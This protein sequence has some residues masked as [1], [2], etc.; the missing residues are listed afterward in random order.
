MPAMYRKIRQEDELTGIT[1][2]AWAPVAIVG[3][4]GVL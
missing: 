4:L 3:Q 2:G 1:A